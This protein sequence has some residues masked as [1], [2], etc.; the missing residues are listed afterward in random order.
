MDTATAKLPRRFC[1]NHPQ[2][3]AIGA[4][5]ITG[6]PI[7]GEC[8]TRYEGI[9]YSREGLRIL[10]ERRA[11]GRPKPSGVGRLLEVFAWLAAPVLLYALY[12]S[13]V[14]S[15]ELLLTLFHPDR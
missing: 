7:C 12:L 9:N 4:C 15:A 3:V 10:K 8:S 2:R 1:S 6:T 13:Y 14:Q 11:A 5:V